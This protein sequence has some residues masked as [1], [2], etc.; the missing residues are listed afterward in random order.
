MD[1]IIVKVA[2]IGERVI[3]VSCASGATVEQILDIADVSL[4]GRS[5]TVNDAAAQ[6]STPV[7]AQNAIVALITKMKGGACAPKKGKKPVKK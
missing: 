3:E 6:L 4:N 7:T 1:N 5:I 2:P